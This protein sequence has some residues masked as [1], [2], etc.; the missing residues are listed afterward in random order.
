M[1]EVTDTQMF[2]ADGDFS[3][4]SGRRAVVEWMKDKRAPTAMIG[5]NDSVALGALEALVDSRLRVP[6][7]VAL[8]GFDGTQLSASPLL[9]LTTVDQ[10]IENLG[11]RSVQILLKQLASV[12]EFDPVREVLPT[13]LLLRASTLGQTAIGLPPPR[14]ARRT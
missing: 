3:V 5:V 8:A 14:K 12:G 2:V 6:D 9:S 7:D 10:H 1:K 4:E 11:Q 13:K